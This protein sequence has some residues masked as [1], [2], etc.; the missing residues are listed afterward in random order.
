M[1][2]KIAE[3][4]EAEIDQ[5]IGRFSQLLEP[6]IMLILGVLIGGLVIG[7]YLPLFKLGSAF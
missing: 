6:L 7:L 4:I 2:D 3:L 1:L 5:L